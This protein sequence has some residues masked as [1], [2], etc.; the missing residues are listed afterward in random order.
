LEM[1]RMITATRSYEM[2]QKA[3]TN[4]DSLD[5]KAITISRVS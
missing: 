2:V 3:I 4:L 1:S 5:E